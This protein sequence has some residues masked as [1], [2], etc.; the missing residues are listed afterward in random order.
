M[1]NSLRVR[2]STA[3]PIR[4]RAK[5][6]FE[7][8]TLL[9]SLHINGAPYRSFCVGVV[10]YTAILDTMG[11]EILSFLDVVAHFFIK[12]KRITTILNCSSKY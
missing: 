3:P 7:G 9:R 6:S 5:H 12:K 10:L 2:P 11:I 1:K 8:E 4:N